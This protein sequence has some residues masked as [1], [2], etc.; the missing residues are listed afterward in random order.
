MPE[1]LRSRWIKQF[2]TWER[3]RGLQFSRAVMPDDAVDSKLRIIAKADFFLANAC[4][5]YL[6]WI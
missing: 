3:L 1:E 5:G 4:H 2:Q 6:V